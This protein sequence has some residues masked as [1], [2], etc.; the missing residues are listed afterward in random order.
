VLTAIATDD[1]TATLRRELARSVPDAGQWNSPHDL[2]DRSA[3]LTMA[4]Q[5]AVGRQRS[6]VA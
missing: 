5:A 3:E 6:R 2:L 4:A 1:R